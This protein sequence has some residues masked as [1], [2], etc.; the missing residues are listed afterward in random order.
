MIQTRPP[1]SLRR[2]HVRRLLLATVVVVT[3]FATAMAPADAQVDRSRPRP[4]HDVERL[5]LDCAPH[6]SDVQR[7]V[8]C[9]WSEARNV[10]TRA[11]QLFRIV[12][13]V[14][15][16]LIATVGVDGRRGYF[17]TDV[18]APSS[19]VYGVISVNRNGRLL[20]RSA[21]VHIQLGA[22]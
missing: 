7:G 8:L 5:R 15:R 13:G 17:D 10:D 1:H 9:R 4:V 11:Y 6:N 12:D 21:P 18:A 14:P 2:S 19:L 20:G 22:G 16:E 3:V